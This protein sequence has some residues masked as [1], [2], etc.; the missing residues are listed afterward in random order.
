M[1][2]LPLTAYEAHETIVIFSHLQHMM[3]RLGHINI[4]VHTLHNTG[5]V[6]DLSKGLKQHEERLATAVYTRK[7]KIGKTWERYVW[8]TYKRTEDSSIYEEINSGKV[9]WSLNQ[10]S[11]QEAHASPTNHCYAYWREL[12]QPSNWLDAVLKPTWPTSRCNTLS[13]DTSTRTMYLMQPAQNVLRYIK[14]QIFHI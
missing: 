11:D 13:H 5:A 8:G 3:L 1:S 6:C 14:C 10:W 9:P 7:I 4:P 12:A 2:L